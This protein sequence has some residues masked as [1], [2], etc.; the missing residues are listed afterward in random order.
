MTLGP[1]AWDAEET[2]RG[3]RPGP[4][5]SGLGPGGHR[6][7]QLPE[8]PAWWEAMTDHATLEA[9]GARSFPAGVGE[10]QQ[11]VRPSSSARSRAI[12]CPPLI[13]SVLGRSSPSLSQ[14]SGARPRPTRDFFG[15]IRPDDPISPPLEA[16]FGFTASALHYA[17][18]RMSFTAISPGLASSY[19]DP[20]MGNC[21]GTAAIRLIDP[22]TWVRS[23]PWRDGERGELVLTPCQPAMPSRC[24]LPHRR[25]H[26]ATGTSRRPSG[27]RAARPER[28]PHDDMVWCAHQCPFP[29]PIAGLI[30]RN[31]AL[32]GEFGSA[33]EGPAAL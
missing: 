17:A 11:L 21:A 16:T 32:S 20:A 3:S 9:T 27:A 8:L 26:P 19:T 23:A 25:Y 29:A 12:S 10:T 6:V 7:V 2:R 5:A 31:D 14:I 18:H 30:N 15:A 22:A 28:R 33:L 4:S 24:A 13:P 1:L